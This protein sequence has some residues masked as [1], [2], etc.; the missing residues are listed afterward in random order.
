MHLLDSEMK[1][2]CMDLAYV[3]KLAKDNNGVKYLL[4]RQKLFD[5]AV[6]ARGMKP[7][8]S[9]E[10]LCAFLTI[11]TKTNRPKEISVGRGTEFA[12][13]FKKLCKAEGIQIYSTLSETMAAVAD[14]TI[15]FLKIILYRYIEDNDYKYIHKLTHFVTGPNC[16]KKCSTDLIPQKV[17]NSEFLSILYSK[18]LQQI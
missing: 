12:G 17:K 7:K 16:K 8:D 13:E 3:D 14:R 9:K 4:F 5:R 2:W 10:M 18:S 15:R 11:N 6:D 1:I